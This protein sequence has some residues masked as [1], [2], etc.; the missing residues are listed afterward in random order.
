VWVSLSPFSCPIENGFRMQKLSW[1]PTKGNFAI[2][3]PT[4]HRRS[5]IG[6]INVFRGA[7]CC[8]TGDGLGS[9]FT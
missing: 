6:F 4:W 1:H 2:S 8:K 7:R 9:E 5:V 3:D